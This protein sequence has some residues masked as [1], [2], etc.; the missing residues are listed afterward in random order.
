MGTTTPPR[1]AWSWGRSEQR[2]LLDAK[3][4]DF[5]VLHD[6]KRQTHRISFRPTC[7]IYAFLLTFQAT[8]WFYFWE[9][10]MHP[11]KRCLS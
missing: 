9:V 7:P 4:E 3:F 11:E 8:P 2:R 5:S 1:Q 10:L 6:P